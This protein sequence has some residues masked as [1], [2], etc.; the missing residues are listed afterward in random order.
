MSK[1][2]DMISIQEITA[3]L[4]DYRIGK[5]PLAKLLGW[6]ETTIIRYMDGDIPTK[7]YSDKLKKIL[8][9][10]LY[11]YDLLEQNKE[12][13]TEVAFKKTKKAV[14]VKLTKSKIRMAAQFFINCYHEEIT[15]IQIQTLLYFAQGFSLGFYEVPLFYDEYRMTTN[16]CP[17][18]D[19][20]EELSAESLRYFDIGEEI[21]TEREKE[22]LQTIAEAFSW[23]GTKALLTLAGKERSALKISRDKQNNK[24]VTENAIRIHFKKLME[25]AEIKELQ[26]IEGYIEKTMN[27]LKHEV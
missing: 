2:E 10:P 11:Y 18:P 25:Q 26:D 3:I 16:N 14:L 15:P 21:F 23:Y 12:S 20:F 27:E 22:L 4:N 8:N 7:E 1:E 6:G 19:L 13:L 5:K 17:Y 9:S 24:V